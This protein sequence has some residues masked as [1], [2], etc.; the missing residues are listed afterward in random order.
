MVKLTKQPKSWK[1]M[2]RQRAALVAPQIRFMSDADKRRQEREL[3][4]GQGPR[5]KK[6]E[7]DG[8]CNRT[9]CQRPLEGKRQYYMRDYGTTDGRLYY[10]EPCERDFSH[11]DRIDRPGEPLRCTLDETT[12]NG[13]AR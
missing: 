12:A 13:A 9:A 5:P 10:C 2:R 1:A 7:K 4:W 6:G 8:L 3:D 11:W